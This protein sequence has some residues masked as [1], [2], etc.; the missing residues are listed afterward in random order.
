MSRDGEAYMPPEMIRRVLETAAA[1]VVLVGGQALA[2]WMDHYDV[3]QPAQAAPAIS[4]DVDFFTHDAANTGPLREFARAIGGRSEPVDPSAITALVGSAIAPAEEGRIYNV[5]LLHSIV[6]L[7]RENVVANAVSVAIPGSR[8]TLRVMH[9]L[10]VLQS[11]NANL[12]SLAEKQ[13]AL[14]QLQFRLAIEVARRHLEERIAAIR[15]DEGIEGQARE[16]AV[17]E[18]IRTVVDYSGEDAAKR[19]AARFGVFLADAIPAWRIRST[20]F[21][22]KEWPHLRGRMS[23]DYAELCEARA[24]RDPPAGPK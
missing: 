14:G 20:T 10:D 9:P 17:L 23:P 1:D 24:E 12:H 11:R 19:N 8:A 5:D 16:R 6:G 13:D 4:R 22:D 18:A 21:W 15:Q 2:F 3:R 7:E